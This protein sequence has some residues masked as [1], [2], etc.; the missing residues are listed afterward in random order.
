MAGNFGVD[1]LIKVANVIL[2]GGNVIEK[3][4]NEEGNGMAKAA[5]AMLL[6]DELMAL[7]T[8][9]FSKLDDEAKELD[10]EDKDKLNAHFKAKLDL[11]DDKIEDA[12]EK[13][14][15]MALKLEGVVR[16]IVALVKSFK[17]EEKEEE[18]VAEDSSSEESS[19]ASAD[20]SDSEATGE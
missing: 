17:E 14:F 4:I 13:T 20:S 6:F 1:N 8:V 11:E 5:H 19:D 10:Q 18:V 15:G 7:P 9:E 16:E 12:I 3:I 2:E